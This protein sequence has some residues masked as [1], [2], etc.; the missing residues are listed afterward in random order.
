MIG[1]GDF[2]RLSGDGVS[3]IDIVVA[4]VPKTVSWEGMTSS[5]WRSVVVFV[6]ENR[7]KSCPRTYRGVFKD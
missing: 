4:H 2:S 1:H 5:D 3:W 6:E 7:H